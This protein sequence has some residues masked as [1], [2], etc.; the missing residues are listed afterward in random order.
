MKLISPREVLQRRSRGMA[1]RRQAESCVPEHR[2]AL[3]STFNLDL[4]PPLLLEAMERVG[5]RAWVHSGPFGQIE[6]EALDPQSGTFQARPDSLI[7][8]PAVEDLLASLF[9][10]PAAYDE[11]EALAMVHERVA[12][13]ER[14]IRALLDGIPEATCY[15]VLFGPTR[16]PAEFIRDPRS[17][18]R[19]QVAVERF[20]R[21]LLELG[22]LSPRVVMVDWDWA[23]RAAGIETLH[24]P[25]LWYLGRMRLNPSGCALLSDLLADHLAAYAGKAYKVAA[26]DLDNTLWGEVVG[27]VGVKGIDLGE[28]GIGLAF[29]EFQR[30]LLRLHDAGVV[31]AAISKNNPDDAMEV[32][33]RHPAMILRREHFAAFRINWTDKATNLRD[34]ARE[35]NVGIDSLVFLDDNPVE[36]EWIRQA[37]PEVLVPELPD[38]PAQRVDFL[39]GAPFFRR[40]EVT[41]ADLK[42]AENYREQHLRRELEAHASS[43]DEFI[44]SLAQEIVIEPLGEATFARAAQMCQRTN[45]FNLTTHRY[46]AAELELMLRDPNVEVYTLSVRDRFG[47]SGITGLA[48]LRYHGAEC[49][50]DTLL[51]SCRILGRRIEHSFLAV[52]ADRAA[53]RGAETLVGRYRPTAKNV[54]VARLY[55]DLGF[56]EAGDGVFRLSLRSHPLRAPSSIAVKVLADAQ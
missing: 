37:V 9:Q 24:D 56:D 53:E 27:E 47:D 33:D 5:V 28:E 43:I 17:P 26:V 23:A 3:L 25:R 8:V 52:L 40:V 31:L 20:R 38:D 35:L 16:A 46:T 44:A 42:R 30:E 36:R 2:I 14:S 48:I 12:G 18:Q 45:Q 21:A 39:R 22:G 1:L 34:V 32:I 55:P 29:Q 19:G 11:D 6:Q 51:L 4:L 15:V 54:Q 41:E 7:L 50:V 49:E 10:R 13:L